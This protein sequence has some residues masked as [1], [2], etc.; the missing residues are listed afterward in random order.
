MLGETIVVGNP[1]ELDRRDPT[2]RNLD[3]LYRFRRL[4]QAVAR[5]TC[6]HDEPHSPAAFDHIVEKARVTAHRVAAILQHG[7]RHW[8]GFAAA[9]LGEYVV[10]EDSETLL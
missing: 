5:S 2:G 3:Q 6:R 1:L 10:G 7:D 8:Q 9:R 4:R